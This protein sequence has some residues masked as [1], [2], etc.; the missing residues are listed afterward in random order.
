[1]KDTEKSKG[2]SLVRLPLDVKSKLQSLADTEDRS[3]VSM[4][5]ILIKEYKDG[6]SSH[7]K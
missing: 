1:M 6:L 3:M 2:S 7:Q 5:K 4:L